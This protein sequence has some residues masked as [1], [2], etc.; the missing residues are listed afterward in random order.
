MPHTT[1][2]S[3]QQV[4]WKCHF[5]LSHSVFPLMR[6]YL[7]VQATS[8]DP[9]DLLSPV[10]SASLTILKEPANKILSSLQDSSS[11]NAKP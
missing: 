7:C 4:L 6:P 10:T 9:M 8:D 5:P 3:T 1:P 11:G 2:N